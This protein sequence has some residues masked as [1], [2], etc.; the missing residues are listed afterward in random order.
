MLPELLAGMRS[1]RSSL[2]TGSLIIVTCYII[3]YNPLGSVIDIQ[4][5]LAAILNFQPW[6]PLA[7]AAIG[8]YLI[9]SIY[10]TALEGGVDWIHRHRIES[11]T[12]SSKFPLNRL[13]LTLSPLSQASLERFTYESSRFYKQIH[14]VHSRAPS[15]VKNE[16]SFMVKNRADLLW[17]EGKLVGSPLKNEYRQY[18]SEGELQLGTALL[19]PFTFGAI[20]HAIGIPVMQSTILEALIILLSI[21][22]AGY[23]LY[24]YR[25]AHSLIAHHIADGNLITPAMETAKRLSV[26]ADQPYIIVPARLQASS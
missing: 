9:G 5:S 11:N 3:F 2:L 10:T 16:H 23:G 18:R 26:E 15:W 22:L 25:R 4:P 12:K 19:L 13:Q 8:T 24:Y 1:F 14:I 21:K 6:M 20:L 7:V 17:M